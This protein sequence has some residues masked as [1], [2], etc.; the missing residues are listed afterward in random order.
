MLLYLNSQTFAGDSGKL[1]EEDICQM[2]A[3][4]VDVVLVHENDEERGGCPFS[5]CAMSKI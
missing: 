2:R 5:R 1:L 4:A 3:R